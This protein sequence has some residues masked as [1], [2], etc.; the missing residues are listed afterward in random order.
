MSVGLVSG[1]EGPSPGE[2]PGPALNIATQASPSVRLFLLAAVVIP[3][4]SLPKRAFIE[5]MTIDHTR[6]YFNLDRQGCRLAGAIGGRCAARNRRLRRLAEMPLPATR[7]V[8]PEVETTHQASLLLDQR[9]PHLRGTGSR[10]APRSA[11]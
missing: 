3:L 2:L 11:G 8:E 10:R 7:P 4:S 5:E 9:F 1:P 6:P